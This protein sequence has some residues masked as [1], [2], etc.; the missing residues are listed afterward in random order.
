M[1]ANGEHPK[2]SSSND[3]RR[4]DMRG[5]RLTDVVI[6]TMGERFYTVRSL[7]CVTKG[8]NPAGMLR[9]AGESPGQEPGTLSP[10]PYPAARVTKGNDLAIRSG[11]TRFHRQICYER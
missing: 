5:V 1:P 8:N 10:H 9:H 11:P 6:V 2:V 4:T 7:C 3:L